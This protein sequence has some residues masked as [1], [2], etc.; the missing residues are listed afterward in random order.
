[1]C[2]V[3][4]YSNMEKFQYVDTKG[5]SSILNHTK[6]LPKLIA[7]NPMMFFIVKIKDFYKRSI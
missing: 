6:N 3:Q 5:K 7:I 2:A 4:P 1:M